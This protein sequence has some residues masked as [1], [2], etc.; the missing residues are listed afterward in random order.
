MWLKFPC[1][2][3]FKT[4]LLLLKNEDFGFF[5]HFNGYFWQFLA[6]FCILKCLNGKTEIVAEIPL[7]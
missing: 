3:N 5:W 6:I 2:E 4:P 1:H 7:S